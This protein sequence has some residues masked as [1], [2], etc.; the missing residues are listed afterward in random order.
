MSAA[1]LQALRV[2]VVGLGSIG[3]RHLENLDRLGVARRVVVR[4]PRGANA[5]FEPPGGV[6][7]GHSL[8][9]ALGDRLDAAIICNPTSL[10]VE[11]ALEYLEAGVAVLIEKPIAHR[12]EDAERLIAA[13]RRSGACAGMAYAM[14][15][16]P[17][18]RLAHDAIADERLG[19]MLYA[20]VWFEAYLP[21]W[22]PWEDYRESYAARRD[23]GGG[24]LP[25]LDHEIDFLNWCLGQAE[26]FE[27]RSG[28]SGALDIDAGDWATLSMRYPGGVM[29][30]G[31]FSLCRR[32]RSRG[33]EFVGERGTLRFNLESSRLVLSRGGEYGAELLWNGAGYDLNDIYLE[34]LRDFL[35]VLVDRRPPPVP[36][37]AGLHAL[38]VA[39]AATGGW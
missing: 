23:L 15:Y 3:R 32:D 30:G 8:Q 26:W 1:S 39:G 29:A 28:R 12:L 22:H 25:T 17:A 36:L 5:A 35:G 11:T 21:D 37:E 14:R 24:A 31:M 2:A 13:A 33:F 4:R 19:R 7:V 34:M 18:Y 38:R 20:K 9:D 27:G 6:A 16:H 10:H